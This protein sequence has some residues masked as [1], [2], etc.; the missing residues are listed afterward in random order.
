M[1]A[2]NATP[3]QG[4]TRRYHDPRGPVGL[5]FA[6]KSLGVTAGHL[7]RVLR[8]ERT[9][10]SLSGRYAALVAQVQRK[11]STPLSHV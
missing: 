8:G 4:Q 11:N 10:I 6:A 9:S 1:I 3:A 7:S 5:R 2:R